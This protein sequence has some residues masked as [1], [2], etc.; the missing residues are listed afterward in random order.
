MRLHWRLALHPQPDIQPPGQPGQEQEEQGEGGVSPQC[1]ALLAYL[2]S[3]VAL[4]RQHLEEARADLA[5]AC[6][7][8]LL[9]GVLLVAR[10]APQLAGCCARPHA[11]AASPAALHQSHP[12]SVQL[13]LASPAA[14]A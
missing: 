10:C 3:L 11:A 7:H 13:S 14:P 1:A 2:R 9:H 6:R 8:N 5:A 12:Q 4:A